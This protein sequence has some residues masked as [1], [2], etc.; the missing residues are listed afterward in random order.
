MTLT[1]TRVEQVIESRIGGFIDQTRELTEDPSKPSILESGSWAMRKLGY[2]VANPVT[3]TDVEVALVTDADM[4]V[5]LDLTELKTLKSIPG[6]LPAVDTTV[7]PQSVKMSN[8]LP[9]L[10]TM[11]QRRQAEITAE[12]GW[13]IP[14]VGKRKAR[15][16]YP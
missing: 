7:G 3:F 16:I 8:L 2:T 15:M 14:G 6:N 10:E 4:D 13:R 5:F 9:A 1:R 12:H 11:I